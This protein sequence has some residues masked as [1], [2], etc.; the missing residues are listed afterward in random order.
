VGLSCRSLTVLIYGLSQSILIVLWLLDWAIW[1]RNPDGQ[2]RI[3]DGYDHSD[4]DEKEKSAN[5]RLKRWAEYVWYCW[6]LVAT[7]LGILTSVGGTR[8]SSVI[9]SST[10]ISVK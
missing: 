9:I 6:F 2:V 10:E 3:S 5:N 1:K 7:G 4:D 8:K